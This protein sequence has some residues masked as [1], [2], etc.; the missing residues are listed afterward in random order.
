MG[1]L[2]EVGEQMRERPFLQEDQSER[3]KAPQ[4]ARRGSP[5]PPPPAA[6]RVRA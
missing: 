6:P 1:Q 4:A 5:P 3:F 2:A